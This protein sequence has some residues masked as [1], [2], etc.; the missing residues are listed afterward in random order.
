M[1][2]LLWKIFKALNKNRRGGR[3]KYIWTYEEVEK[4]YTKKPSKIQKK[5]EI[6]L[7]IKL[8]IKEDAKDMNEFEK[9]KILKNR[10]KLK[11]TLNN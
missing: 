2:W 1:S 6:K 10:S 7:I 9:I 5:C 8:T 3:T 4:K 11:N